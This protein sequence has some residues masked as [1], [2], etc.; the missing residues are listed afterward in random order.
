MFVMSTVNCSDKL[1]SNKPLRSAPVQKFKP[2]FVALITTK[3]TGQKLAGLAMRPATQSLVQPRARSFA[4]SIK[5][6][7]Q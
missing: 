4:P 2:V 1:T 6:E 7:Y 3:G 5:A